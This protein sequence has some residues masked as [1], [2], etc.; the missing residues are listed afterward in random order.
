VSAAALSIIVCAIYL[1]GQGVS[2]LVAPNVI[3]PILGLPE[4][5]DIW[6]RIVGMTVC[7]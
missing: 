7:S 1:L 3:L 6:V 2:L 5:T 4:S